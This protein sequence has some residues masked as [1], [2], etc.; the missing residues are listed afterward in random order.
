MASSSNAPAKVTP[1]A[2]CQ[3]S[4]A[5][6]AGVLHHRCDIHPKQIADLFHRHV[7]LC[8]APDIL[9]IMRIVALARE[10]GHQPLTPLPLYRVENA[11][12]VVDQ[13]IAPRWVFA[14]DS[15]KHLLLV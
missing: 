15:G 4:R 12:L 6:L 5:A 14:G 2:V 13:H 1:V 10:H 8:V 7:W 11:L 9:G 3:S